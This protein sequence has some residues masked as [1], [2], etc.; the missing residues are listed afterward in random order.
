MKS[1]KLKI[2][3]NLN[4]NFAKI[5]NE[6]QIIKHEQ[7]IINILLFTL[8]IIFSF[9]IIY[10]KNNKTDINIIIKKEF[11]NALINNSNSNSKLRNDIFKYVDLNQK[12]LESY[13]NKQND[14]C[15]NPDKYYNKEIEE[16]IKLHR[17]KFNDIE[18]SMF[19]YKG[20]DIVSKTLTVYTKFEPKETDNILYALKYYGEKK[21]IK[22]NKDIF[23]LDIGGN[24][25]WYPAYL[26]RFGYSILTFEPFEKN[27]YILRKNICHLYNNS[28]I[29]IINKGLSNEEKNCD[30]YTDID[31]IGNGMVMCDN[32]IHNKEIKKEFRKT[33]EIS[34]TKLSN[35]IPYL[36]D[37]NLALIKID[38]EGMEGKAIKGGIEF[39]NKYH[40]P[41][42][43]LEFTPRALIEHGTDPKKFLQIFVDNGYKI[44]T[45]GFFSENN[46]SNE[47]LVSEVKELLNIYIVYDGY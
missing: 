25:G 26:G 6:L 5:R 37:K 15:T 2:N 24:I 9:L 36:Y 42:I 22:N 47:N 45:D 38:I 10:L 7:I 46:I 29:V 11:S 21:N 4:L 13:I 17:V 35:F 1:N 19:M 12:I 39:I 16:E 27:Y 14:F 32:E 31:N 33:G 18:F 40:I 8:F 41:Y 28:N 3:K 23:M 43:L 34:L 20:Q 30:F 44:K